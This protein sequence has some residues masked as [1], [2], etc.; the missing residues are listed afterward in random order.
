MGSPAKKRRSFATTAQ[1]KSSHNEPMISQKGIQ[2]VYVPSYTIQVRSLLNR[3]SS[4]SSTNST[5]RRFDNAFIENQQQQQQQA[6]GSSSSFFSLASPTSSSSSSSSMPFQR[7]PMAPP[8]HP[9]AQR[10][11]TS[12]QQ[13]LNS[14]NEFMM[15]HQ[16][17]Q[18]PQPQTQQNDENYTIPTTS[19]ATNSSNP[20]NY[21]MQTSFSPYTI[22]TSAFTTPPELPFNFE[23]NI[24]NNENSTNN[25]N[26]EN[27][28]RLYGF[29]P[30]NV[31]EEPSHVEQQQ[32]LQRQQHEYEQRI[33][34]N[35]SQQQQQSNNY[36]LPMI[37]ST[38]DAD[39]SNPNNMTAN[40][41]WS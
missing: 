37:R 17:Y 36:A 35:F 22:P 14:P 3:S 1:Q 38:E 41:N 2:M 19:A 21:N 26:D 27:N 24:N 9:P 8:P 23:Q 4:E 11:M 40:T 16:S 18:T 25:A 5:G 32:M 28:R 30:N 20:N 39:E 7:H 10:G 34:R 31:K 12:P 29:L 15:S 33:H 13:S 6:F